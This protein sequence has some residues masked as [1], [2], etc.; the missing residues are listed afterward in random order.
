MRARSVPGRSRTA[1]R[2]TVQPAEL[3]NQRGLRSRNRL[4]DAAREVLNESGYR[5]LRVQDVTERAGVASGLFYRYFHDLRE[6][7][8]E[9]AS[10]FFEVLISNTGTLEVSGDP[11]DW[12]YGNHCYVVERFAE[13]PEILACL[14]GLA[15]DYEEFDAIWKKNA[16]SWNLQ[17]ADFL[18]SE[19]GFG[20]ARAERMGYVLGAMT[21]GVIYQ[22]LIRHTEDLYTLGSH[23]SDIA[24]IIAVMWYRAIFL[25]EPPAEKLGVIGSRLQEN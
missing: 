13:N 3:L 5:N 25:R 11:Y 18:R 14:F 10:D 16:H 19:A 8:G 23:P 24:E 15:G 20:K 9:I 2:D 4:K 22:S 21:E 12:I 1:R 17:V 7:V 6:I